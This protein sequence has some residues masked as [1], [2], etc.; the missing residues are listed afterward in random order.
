MSYL[1]STFYWL[2][3]FALLIPWMF[4][5]LLLSVFRPIR[6]HH[7]FHR[8]ACGW[9]L[10]AFGIR[11]VVHG[12]THIPLGRGVIFASNHVNLFEPFIG[13]HAVPSW[14]V[15]IEKIEN[16]RLPIYG[17]FIRRWGNIG[18]DRSDLA[19]AKASLE[20]AQAC[21]AD[22]VS[23]AIMPEGTRTKDGQL[24]PFK[25]GPFHLA[26]E[27]GALIIPYAFKGA[28]AIQQT[29]RFLL[30]PGTIDVIF[31]PP[32]DA[33]L[34]TKDNLEVLSDAVR[35]EILCALE[36]LPASQTNDFAAFQATI[37]ITGQTTDNSRS[38]SVG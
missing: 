10:R 17:W 4:L 11:V 24:Q 25:K 1:W 32:I 36:I 13:I 6:D 8:W 27:T 18:I 31:R 29:G 16:F 28:Y 34:Y 12:V 30:K 26:I 15:A 22:G 2:R 19:A 33:S 9:I 35:K 5:T 7:G 38:D 3:G 20:R 23:I 14:V 37:E 21:L